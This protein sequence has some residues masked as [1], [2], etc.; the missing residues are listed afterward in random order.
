[1]A[2]LQV[3]VAAGDIILI[4]LRE[5]QDDKAD[6]IVK[7]TA[8]EARELKA[9]KEIPES[10]VI[11][12][13]AVAGPGMEEEGGFEFAAGDDSDDDSDESD[14]SVDVDKI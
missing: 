5:Y 9:D 4:S 1:V 10:V 7:Y 8:D 12:E 14:D 6:V 13:S 2:C 11:N 3:W